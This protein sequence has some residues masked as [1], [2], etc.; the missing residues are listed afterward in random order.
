MYA[1]KPIGDTEFVCL[2]KSLRHVEEGVIVFDNETL[3]KSYIAAIR[4][5]AEVVP[6]TGIGITYTAIKSAHGWDYHANR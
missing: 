5:R 3:A 6:Y 4:L 1:I 2:A